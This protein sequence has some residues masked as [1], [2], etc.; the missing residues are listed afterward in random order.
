[1]ERGGPK[2]G[3]QRGEF[4]DSANMAEARNRVYWAALL[5]F[6]IAGVSLFL[7][8]AFII[9]P[10]KYQSPTALHT[11][12]VFRQFAPAGTILAACAVLTLMWVLWG[13]TGR[14]QRIAMV[15]AGVLV[16][17]AATMARLNYFEWMFHPVAQPGF[18]KADDVKLDAGE[19]VLTLDF[20][21]DTRAYPV[22]E[23][24]YHHIVND[25]VGGVPV[26][27]TY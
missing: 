4:G 8:P 16:L 24:A 23:M 5:A 2:L 13:R 14:V 12:L 18:L 20:N 10:F 21:G 15:L 7:V 19:M 9:R 25:V 3:V 26:A 22:R 17:G 27:V 1:M 11:A 6:V